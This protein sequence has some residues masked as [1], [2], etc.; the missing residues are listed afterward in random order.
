MQNYMERNQRNGVTM[1]CVCESVCVWGGGQGNNVYYF[2]VYKVT[3]KQR[4]VITGFKQTQDKK[5]SGFYYL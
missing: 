2:G 3:I 4:N 5:R 1:M